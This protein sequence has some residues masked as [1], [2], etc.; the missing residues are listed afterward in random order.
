M[1]DSVPDR[2][3]EAINAYPIKFIR[4]QFTDILGLTKNVE[5]P[6]SQVDKAFEEGIMFDGSSVE[7]FARINESDMRLR[8]D[9][10]TFEVLPWTLPE[11]VPAI[12]AGLF[13]GQ[14][15]DRRLSR[16]TN[17]YRGVTARF[18]C[19]IQQPD[20]SE[21][22]GCARTIL[23][24]QIAYAAKKGFQMMAGP[25]M[26]FFLFEKAANGQPT[27]QTHDAAGY[28]DLLPVDR[29]E[30]ARH[31]MVSALEQMGFEIEAAHHEVA[32]SQHE[33]DF[34]YAD[35]LTTADRVVTFRIVVKTVALDH[36]LHATFMPKPIFGEN[37]SGMHTNQS[38]FKD[39]VN[40]FEEQG[41][42]MGLS[43]TCRYY[44]AGLIEHTRGMSIFTNPTI[45]SYK[46]LVPGFEAPVR[47]AWSERNRSPLIRIPASRGK[48]T[49]VELRHPDPSC[50]PYLAL[51]CMLGAGLDGVEKKTMPPPPIDENVYE[52]SVYELK[53]RNIGTL[54]ANVFE[55]V[56]AFEED[57]L[58]AKIVGA[59]VAEFTSRAK[60]AEWTEYTSQ[61]TSWEQ[62]RYLRVY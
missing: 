2:I 61:V 47:I 24:K 23:K 26:E 21:F 16:F 11:Y 32:P 38:L 43:D 48:S 39:G 57:P 51:A 35:A 50:N 14:V 28:F 1:P 18:I 5:V 62:E 34:K 4:L 10:D 60:R 19:D 6:V 22:A 42:S 44:I 30:E 49:R 52:L 17:P 25:E 56:K 13:P 55:A 41:G 45:N 20:G 8:P 27:T 33:I 37:G 31:D 3:R 46:R 59:H 53:Q 12:Q 36:G 58:I 9:P 7:G 29:G 54:P 40:A 15:N